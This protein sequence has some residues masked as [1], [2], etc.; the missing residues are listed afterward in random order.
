MAIMSGLDTNGAEC[1]LAGTIPVNTILDPK[2]FHEEQPLHQAVED[3]DES[4]LTYLN[5]WLSGLYPPT[6]VRPSIEF[7]QMIAQAMLEDLR[8]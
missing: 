2:G 4:A 8:E 3:T 5:H 6:M 1:T 7:A